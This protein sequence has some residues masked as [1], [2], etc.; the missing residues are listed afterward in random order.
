MAVLQS[1]P[2]IGPG[3]LYKDLPSNYLHDVEARQT[4]ATL[5]IVVDWSSYLRGV[6]PPHNP[7]VTVVLKNECDGAFT[8]TV[9]ND[10]V[11]FEG[12]GDLHD[13]KYDDLER[14]AALNALYNR[15]REERSLVL[16]EMHCPFNLQVYPTHAM[17][18][19]HIPLVT[20]LAVGFVFVFTAAV[21][22]V[23]N[24]IVEHRQAI[25]LNQA[26]QS[27]AIVSSFLPDATPARRC[28]PASTVYFSHR[29]RI[30]GICEP[31]TS[32]WRW[33]SSSIASPSPT[34]KRATKSLFMNIRMVLR[35]IRSS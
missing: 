4:I 19:T 17:E 10:N 32:Q 7:P 34:W 28:R 24:S 29:K 26:T 18:G 16:D 3:T 31:V 33:T 6:V 9:D 21:F 11:I 1:A 22:W 30:Q 14:S 5:G 23:Y 25:V 8:Y 13:P 27:A 20:T 2:I 12:N 35:P 15:V